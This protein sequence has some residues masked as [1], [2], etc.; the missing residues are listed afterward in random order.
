[1]ILGSGVGGVQDERTTEGRTVWQSTSEF[2]RAATISVELMR[3]EVQCELIIC[4][5]LAI[6]WLVGWLVNWMFGKLG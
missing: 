4:H 1:V 6:G 2:S 3:E 5:L